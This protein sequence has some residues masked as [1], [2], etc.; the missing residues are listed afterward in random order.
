MNKHCDVLNAA[1]TEREE[2]A[3]RHIERMLKRLLP[4]AELAE[5]VMFNIKC[6]TALSKTEGFGQGFEAAFK[7][8]DEKLFKE[9]D[10]F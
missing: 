10:E 4:N 7:M 6:T 3:I 1:T 2:A 5:A 8:V 9:K